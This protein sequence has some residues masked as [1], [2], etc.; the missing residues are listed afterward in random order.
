LDQFLAAVPT[1]HSSGKRNAAMLTLMA[2]TGLRRGEALGLKTSDLIREHG[3]D[4]VTHLRVVGKGEKA[5]TVAVTTRAA[6]RLATWLAA[7]AGLGI[8]NGHVF[9]T[10]SRGRRGGGFGTRDYHEPGR[11]LQPSYVNEL[12]ARTAEKAG[13]DR[14]VTPHT[15][16]HTFA[17]HL[18]RGTGNLELT[19]KA[20][21]H[22]RITTTAT[23]YSHL[24]ERDVEEAVM[25]LRAEPED[26][27][28][29]QDAAAL[30]EVLATL[31]PQQREKLA[32][33]LLARQEAS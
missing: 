17:T 8:G 18:L 14:R 25:K 9:C 12:V 11:P 21:R 22:S 23:I 10:I 27:R 13:I 3:G 30:A 32:A 16:R 31:T 26:A 15:L 4:V 24:A 33:A 29:T 28:E 19:R 2:D 7:R 1:R 5:A 20:L 6:A